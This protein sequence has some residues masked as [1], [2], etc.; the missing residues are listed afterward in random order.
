VGAAGAGGRTDPFWA[1]DPG[2]LFGRVESAPGGLTADQAAARRLSVGPNQLGEGRRTDL[3]ALIAQQLASPIVL[4]LLAATIL[5]GFLGDPSDAAI[6]LAIVALSAALG[7]WQEHGASQAVKRLL[8]QVA[9][10]ARVVRDGVACDVALADV[11]PGDVALL[12]AGRSVPGDGRLLEA[13]DLFVSEAPLTGESEPAEK[14]AGVSPP[15]APLARR[16]GAVFLGT[17]VVS[18]VARVLIVRTGPRTELGRVAARVAARPPETEFE[19][20][21][22]RFGYLLMEVTL[23]LVLAIFA[24]NVYFERPVLESLMFSLA[25]AIGLTPQLLPAI[26]AVNL[27]RGASRMAA[28]KTIVRRLASIENLGSMTVLCADKTGTLTEGRLAFDAAVDADGAASPRALRLA[29]LNAAHETGYASPLDQALRELA[30]APV[31]PADKR[32]EIPFDFVRRRL[33][34]LVGLDGGLM[35]TKGAVGAV[36]DVCD[37]VETA[38]GVVPLAGRRA[39]IEAAFTRACDDGLRVIGVAFRPLPGRAAVARDDEHGMTFAGLLRF[40]DPPKS[41][42]PAALAELAGLGVALKIVTGDNAVAARALA[43][44]LGRPAPVIAT[45]TDLRHAAAGALPALA[46]K[47]DIFA[48]VEPTQKEQIVSAL[49]RAGHVVGFLGDGINDAPALHAADVGISVAGAADVAREAAD[50]VLLEPGLA[51]V[52]RGLREGRK[53]F[54]NTL[55]Y[56][57]MATSANFG[58]MFS[59]AGASLFLPFLPLMPKQ[60]LLTNVLTDLPEMAIASDSVDDEAVAQ[61][62]RWDVGL[63]RRFMIVFGLLSSVFDYLTFGVLLRQV[64]A[65]PA[66]FRTGW[67]IESV[68]SA[69]S[70]VLVVRSQRP[71]GQSRPGRA[72]V[73]ATALCLAATVA[74]PFSPLAAPLGLAPPAPRVLALIAAIVGAY[75]AAAEAVKRWFFRSLRGGGAPPARGLVEVGIPSAK[76]SGHE[77]R[78]LDDLANQAPAG[79]RPDALAGRASPDG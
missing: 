15:D 13:R 72:L 31:D 58:N 6:V 8:A 49:R 21:L 55:K 64:G 1:W 9:T 40:H 34:V 60:V 28:E 11:V 33:S 25:L 2:E 18:G 12:D 23:L 71:L 78:E 74:L 69:A 66:A 29:F 65:R 51:V 73:R 56:V 63:V 37:S 57:F 45:G 35:I 22:R 47:V 77:P 67:F 19:R 26:V 16:P 32:D 3:P 59:M 75:V 54:A 27:A 79:R 53:T 70:V 30:V 39:A 48:E 24:V 10:Q 7:V 5:A 44:R 4:I 20:G 38:A 61:P 14:A 52:A 17:H 68:L 41:D 46:R 62:R 76:H 43:R 36:L 42:A 50:I